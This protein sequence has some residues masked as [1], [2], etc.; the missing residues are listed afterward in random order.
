MT[1]KSRRFLTVDYEQALE[2][3]VALRE[4]LPPDHFATGTNPSGDYLHLLRP[5]I[6]V[7]QALANGIFG[8]KSVA[9]IGN[10]SD[11]QTCG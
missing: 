2:Q 4:V 3:T 6:W 8:G 9:Q 7:E 1:P 10:V 11:F 5:H